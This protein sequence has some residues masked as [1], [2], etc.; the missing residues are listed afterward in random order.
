MKITPLSD[1]VFLQ[2]LEEEKTTQSGIVIPDTADKERPVRGKIV[3]VGPGRLND[4]GERVAMS[5]KVGQIV[6]FKKYG[7]DEI[8]L[9][10][11]TGKKVEYLAAREE[12]ILAIID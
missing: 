4:K 11:E 7:P 1:H 10:D 9:R 5:V 12:D 8:E 3:A 2:S 6:L